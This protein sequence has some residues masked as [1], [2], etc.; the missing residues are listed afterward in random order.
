MKFIVILKKDINIHS[1]LAK[2]V[3]LVKWQLPQVARHVLN[4]TLGKYLL[5]TEQVVQIAQ[6][7]DIKMKRAKHHV[8]LAV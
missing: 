8:N 3:L 4:A 6:M 2:G 1:P 5:T 7:E